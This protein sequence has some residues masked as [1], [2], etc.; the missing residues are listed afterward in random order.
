MKLVRT[1]NHTLK[2]LP[3]QTGMT[4]VPVD[5][6]YPDEFHITFDDK[7][8]WSVV[9]TGLKGTSEHIGVGKIFTIGKY[10]YEVCE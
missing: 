3:D 10:T 9:G 1:T 8:N 5:S 6:R 2:Q 4:V 7:G